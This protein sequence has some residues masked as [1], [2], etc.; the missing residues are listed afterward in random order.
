MGKFQPAVDD[1]PVVNRWPRSRR[2]VPRARHEL[3]A[4]LEAWGLPG[5][6]DPAG[7]VLS[8]L[9]TNAVRHAAT[10]PG[11]EIETRFFRLSD[12]RVRIEVHDASPARPVMRRTA[13]TDEGGR[14]LPLVDAVTA[15]Q[16][17]VSSRGGVGK[18]VW[19]VIADPARC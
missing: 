19:A 3:A 8:E 18:L 17:G 5:L 15:H 13:E 7:L 12:D 11:R 4:T 16:W 9:V 1:A 2:T 6:V 14:G 10:P